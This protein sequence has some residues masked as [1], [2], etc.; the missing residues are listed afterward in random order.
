[1]IAALPDGYDTRVGE[2][3]AMLSGGERQ[4]IAIART[5]LKNPCILVF[6]EATSALDAVSE[7][8]ITEELNRLARERTTLVVAHRL[9]T[10]MHADRI[11]VMDRGR[12]VE[13]GRH[14][15]LLARQ[16]AYARLWLLQQR[17]DSDHGRG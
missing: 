10:V 4:R 5:I 9:S 16:G 6:D 1:M 7:H 11:V 17:I 14:A 13:Q 8:A 12:I 2:R 3:G 15:E